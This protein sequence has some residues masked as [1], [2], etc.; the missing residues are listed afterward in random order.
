MSTV[1]IHPDVSS[2]DRATFAEILGTAGISI[3]TDADADADV[4]LT[5]GVTYSGTPFGFTA[6]L[7]DVG[8][9]LDGD[10]ADAAR[11]LVREINGEDD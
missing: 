1:W 9:R 8:V 3:T 4:Y 2:Q 10:T 5:P 11:E 6:D 7:G